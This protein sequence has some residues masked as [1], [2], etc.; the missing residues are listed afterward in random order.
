LERAQLELSVIVSQL[1]LRVRDLLRVGAGPV[2][3][4]AVAPA[5]RRRP[6]LEWGFTQAM[7]VF[8][9]NTPHAALAAAA[10][11][12]TRD[13]SARVTQDVLLCAGEE[14]HYVPLHQLYDQARWLTGAR[15]VTTRVV[16]RLDQAQKPLPNRKSGAGVAHHLRMDRFDS[17]VE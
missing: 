4:A 2:L 15:S 1:R 8:G 7:H 6:V 9:V 5:M 16:T 11:Y 17:G 13:V 3:D 10:Q 12:R 14:D